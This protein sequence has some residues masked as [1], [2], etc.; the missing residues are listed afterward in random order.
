MQLLAE[1]EL[2]NGLARSHAGEGAEEGRTRQL[3]F[4]K[5]QPLIFRLLIFLILATANVSTF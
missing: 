3:T 1:E 4:S 5:T 2:C